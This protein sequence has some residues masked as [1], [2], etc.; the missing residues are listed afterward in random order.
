[1][2]SRRPLIALT[3]VAL[4]GTAFALP[5]SACSDSS[6]AED[7]GLGDAASEASTAAD[8]RTEAS[9]LVDAGKDATTL[10][11][12][13]S[14]SAT[15][16]S[17]GTEA[18]TL[19]DARADARADAGSDAGSDADAAACTFATRGYPDAVTSTARALATE[20]ERGGNVGSCAAS[21]Q[22]FATANAYDLYLASRADGGIGAPPQDAGAGVNWNSEVVAVV[23]VTTNVVL[24]QFGESGDAFVFLGETLC[25]GVAPQCELRHFAVPTVARTVL[26]VCPYPGVCMAP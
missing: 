25:Q 23:P 1:M 10:S 17:T 6:S 7:G 15:D 4:V 16:S 21:I 14:D 5:L 11:D 8:A 3:V 12:G 9:A 2:E 22:T 13:A 24:R 19:T 18:S 26:E 20:L